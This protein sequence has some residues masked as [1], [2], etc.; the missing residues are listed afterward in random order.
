MFEEKVPA[1]GERLSSRKKRGKVLHNRLHAILR[2]NRRRVVFCASAKCVCVSASLHIITWVNAKSEQEPQA[3]CRCLFYSHPMIVISDPLVFS[4]RHQ[5]TG[6][7][8]VKWVISLSLHFRDT[9]NAKGWADHLSNR[10][11]DA[12][13]NPQ[14]VCYNPILEF[15]RRFVTD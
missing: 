7:Q 8:V 12:K 4:L 9:L 6:F 10:K 11:R 1:G 2:Y 5:S 3:G 13:S 14:F 15:G